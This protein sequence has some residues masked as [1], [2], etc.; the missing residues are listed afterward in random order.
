MTRASLVARL[1][2]MLQDR[3]GIA[4]VVAVERSPNP[5]ASSRE[6][7]DWLVHVEGG[8]SISLIAKR[9]DAGGLL[10]TAAR[11]RP[12]E[13]YSVGREIAAYEHLFDDPGLPVPRFVGMLDQSPYGWLVTVA[14][15]GTPLAE[16]G[17]LESWCKAAVAAARMHDALAPRADDCGSPIPFDRHTPSSNRRWYDRAIAALRRDEANDDESCASMGLLEALRDRVP[18]ALGALSPTIVHGELYASNILMTSDDTVFVDFE[19][20][21]VAPGPVDLAAIVTGWAGAD[22]AH[23]VA[24]YREASTRWQHRSL[25]ELHH[26]VAA[27][28]VQY[29]AQWLG[30]AHD[31]AP[32]AAHRTD[33]HAEL[34]DAAEEYG[35]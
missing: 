32:P 34:R 20:L 8:S 17:P 11:T 15:A 26:I 25:D 3:L 4:G 16:I 14:V 10:P 6:L 27:A 1:G 5:Y 19:T 23:M 24:A 2:P 7:E 13:V 12:A 31:W 29:A 22:R 35:R 30:W 28:R 18:S 33:W 9:V 21:A